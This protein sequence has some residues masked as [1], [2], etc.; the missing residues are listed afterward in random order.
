MPQKRDLGPLCG[1]ARG[2]SVSLVRSAPKRGVLVVE[3]FADTRELLAELLM[4]E[5]YHSIMASNGVEALKCLEEIHADVVV[6]DLVMPDLGGAELVR[7][8]ASD[9]RLK[10]IPIILLT[11]SGRQKALEELGERAGHVRAILTKPVKLDELLT[12]V[13]AA[14]ADGSL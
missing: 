12:S 4:K 13:E 11:G 7:R 1:C 2:H 9:P 3:D 5:G 10:A 8:M 6:T 14:L